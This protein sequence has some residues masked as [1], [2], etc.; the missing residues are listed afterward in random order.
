[1]HVIV[2]ADT[3]FGTVEFLQAVPTRLAGGG[4]MRCNRKLKMVD[5]QTALPVTASGTQQIKVE[6]ITLHS[7][8][9]GS[10]SNKPMANE[11]CALSYLRILILSLSGALRAKT[12][13]N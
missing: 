1:M 7:L 8:F 12:L 13:G 9:L 11:N 4:G 2:L 3:E 10:G 6:G 5:V